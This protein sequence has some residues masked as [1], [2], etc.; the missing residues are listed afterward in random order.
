MCLRESKLEK[1]KL[2]DGC[3]STDLVE[4]TYCNGGC[5]SRSYI[6]MIAG[7]SQLRS[8][9]RCCKPASMVDRSVTLDCNNNVR[10][11][12]NY[13]IINECSCEICK[14]DEPYGGR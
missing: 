12:Y 5:P 10:K 3:V 14:F 2:P 13:K 1:L 6:D 4:F 9:C 7:Q 11:T 8:E